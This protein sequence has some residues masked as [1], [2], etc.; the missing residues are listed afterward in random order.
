MH[1][2]PL[3]CSIFGSFP[4]PARPCR[5]LMPSGLAGDSFSEQRSRGIDYCCLCVPG[6]GSQ[7]QEIGMCP[8]SPHF[9]PLVSVKH[10]QILYGFKRKGKDQA[11]WTSINKTLPYNSDEPEGRSI[12]LTSVYRFHRPLQ[13][14]TRKAWVTAPQQEADLSLQSEKDVYTLCVL[15]SP[16]PGIEASQP[17]SLWRTLVGS[18]LRPSPLLLL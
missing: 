4:L 12:Y 5:H 10:P 6:V 11:K 8:S 2:I 13:R 18:T 7:G 1:S 17:N 14:G 15:R 3:S 9:L 16:A